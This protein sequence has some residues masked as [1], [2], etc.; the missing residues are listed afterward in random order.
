MAKTIF[1][2][3][4]DSKNGAIEYHEFL[5]HAIG[6]KQLSEINIST[7]FNVIIPSD[8]ILNAD[9]NDNKIE[10]CENSSESSTS[11]STFV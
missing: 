6:Q 5:A 9:R 10:N 3:I 11:K 8:Q 2:I 4:D 7:F 1:N